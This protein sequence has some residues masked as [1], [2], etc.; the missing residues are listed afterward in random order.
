MAPLTSLH[1]QALHEDIHGI[2]SRLVAVQ[3]PNFCHASKV[4]Q[5]LGYLYMGM[6]RYMAVKS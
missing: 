4:V 5:W 3:Q 2:N 1:K 6:Q